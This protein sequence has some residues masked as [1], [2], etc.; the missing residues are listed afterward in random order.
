MGCG[1]G[2]EGCSQI[3]VSRWLHT[4]A[5]TPRHTHRGSSLASSVCVHIA[6]LLSSHIFVGWFFLKV[7]EAKES[8]SHTDV[9]PQQA[10]GSEAEELWS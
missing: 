6:L 10:A 8:K 7:L 4:D 2:R 3:V 1:K 9:Q 5:H